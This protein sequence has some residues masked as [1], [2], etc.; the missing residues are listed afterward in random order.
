MPCHPLCA[1]R[2]ASHPHQTC[3]PP[4]NHLLDTYEVHMHMPRTTPSGQPASAPVTC[5]EMIHVT[6]RNFIW[7]QGQRTSGDPQ[8]VGAGGLARC[9]HMRH[10]RRQEAFP[11]QAGRLP[12]APA[13]LPHSC[14]PA[15]G[16]FSP[17]SLRA[18]GDRSKFPNG[19]SVTKATAAE[20]A[21][22]FRS[23]G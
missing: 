8:W 21:A 16:S 13:S 19:A 1:P 20:A 12:A 9:A 23:A 14:P 18:E 15:T 5:N 7:L 3:I 11:A 4:H 2:A 22:K 10:P 6:Y 17:L